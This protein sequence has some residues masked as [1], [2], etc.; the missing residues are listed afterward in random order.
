MNYRALQRLCYASVVIAVTGYVAVIAAAGLAP[1][2]MLGI[3]RE[4]A[5]KP[6]S[7]MP[8]N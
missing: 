6:P 8:A 2:T 1:E 7:P 4:T 3:P 5:R